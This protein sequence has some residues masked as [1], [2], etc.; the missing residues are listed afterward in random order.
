MDSKSC[1]LVVPLWPWT[2]HLISPRPI[3]PG[4]NKNKK[5]LSHQILVQIRKS[6]GEG[7]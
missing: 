6:L 3:F 5:G 1:V 4:V 7:E 2:S